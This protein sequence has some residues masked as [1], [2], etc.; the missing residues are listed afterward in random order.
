MRIYLSPT[1]QKNFKM[2]NIL[3][4]HTDLSSSQLSYICED[5]ENW[6]SWDL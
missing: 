3:C 4:Q 2:S 5:A 6:E 1:K